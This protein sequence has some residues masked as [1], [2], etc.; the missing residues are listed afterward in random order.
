MASS[1]PCAHQPHVHLLTQG[2]EGFEMLRLAE[3]WEEMGTPSMGE[4]C[5]KRLRR[6]GMRQS[7]L[8]LQPIWEHLLGLVSVTV[9]T[10]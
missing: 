4:H 6:G 5:P 9:G 1:F 2:S 10:R 7:L 8:G 3:R